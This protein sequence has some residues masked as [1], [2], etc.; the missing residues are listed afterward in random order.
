MTPVDRH[1]LVRPDATIW[2]WTGGTAGCP[3]VVLLHGA[4]LD[5]R[6]WSPQAEALQDR[7]RLVAPDLRAHGES[8]GSFDFEAAVHDVFARIP[9][10]SNRDCPRPDIRRRWCRRRPRCPPRFSSYRSISRWESTPRAQRDGAAAGN[11]GVP[12]HRWSD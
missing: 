5:H 6:A 8:T 2:Y 11:R 7:F 4:T 1:E 3:T 10:V 12:V 9:P